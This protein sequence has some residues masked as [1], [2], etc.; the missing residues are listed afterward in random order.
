SKFRKIHGSLARGVRAADNVDVAVSIRKRVGH[1][2][3]IIHTGAAEP[4]QSRH[5]ELSESNSR[6]NEQRPAADL[7]SVREFQHAA[8]TF[9][10]HAADFLGR[11]N[12]RSKTTRLGDGTTREIIAAESHR[13][14][15]VVFNARTSTGLS[16]GSFSFDEQRVQTIRR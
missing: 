6:S 14:T 4:F 7:S 11:K 8:R 13:K 10:T 1:G 12:L 9:D 3:I 16:A 5:V 2:R 15:K